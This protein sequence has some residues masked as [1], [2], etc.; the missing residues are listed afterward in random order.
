MLG[1]FLTLSSRLRWPLNLTRDALVGLFNGTIR[2]WSDPLILSSNPYLAFLS[3]NSTI[4]DRKPAII[5]RNDTGSGQTATVTSS[6]SSFSSAWNRTYG[7]F[8]GIEGWPF[9]DLRVPFDRIAV[10]VLLTDFSISYTDLHTAWAFQLPYVSVQNS[11][12]FF[13]RPT[14]TS[15]LAAAADF[16]R[17]ASTA[18]I[19]NAY[20]SLVNGPGRDTYPIT[21]LTYAVVKSGNPAEC[22]DAYEL[23]RYVYWIVSTTP[24]ATA[25]RIPGSAVIAQVYG[26][27]A[28]SQLSEGTLSAYPALAERVLGTLH[29]SNGINL[30]SA[31]QSDLD[32]E[33]VSIQGKI[34]VISVSVMAGIILIAAG[35]LCLWW[36]RTRAGRRRK[37]IKGHSTKVE[38]PKEAK[39]RT[40]KELNRTVREMKGGSTGGHWIGAPPDTEVSKEGLHNHVAFD[41]SG[42]DHAEVHGDKAMGKPVLEGG[43][44]TDEVPAPKPTSRPL[45]KPALAPTRTYSY[46]SANILADGPSYQTTLIRSSTG[47]L[48]A[49]VAPVQYELVGSTTS[50]SDNSV[51]SRVAAPIAVK[52]RWQ[53]SLALHITWV[54][55]RTGMDLVATLLNWLG[56]WTLPSGLLLAGVY[57]ALCVVGSLFFVVNAFA[58]LA[59]LYYHK[60]KSVEVE[61]EAIKGRRR[62]SIDQMAYVKSEVRRLHV[63]CVREIIYRI[64]LVGRSTCGCSYAIDLRVAQCLPHSFFAKCP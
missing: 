38:V 22:Q 11:A 32:A 31:V 40:Q 41:E 23:V 20:V 30:L 51:G 53:K 49:V 46:P 26:F 12:G 9:Y 14:N 3:E 55:I 10:S 42:S 15:L 28:V 45:A 37:V 5:V 24:Q 56:F 50:G 2:T 8:T 60:K 58:A 47:T 35:G 36:N 33:K 34:L 21:S 29:C 19:N 62:V 25:S 54:A 63:I 64:S 52:P 43:S 7:N 4:L 48:R 18:N 1:R 13:T 17:E 59:G 44:P 61:A 39:E 27:V 6:F 16:A 57:A